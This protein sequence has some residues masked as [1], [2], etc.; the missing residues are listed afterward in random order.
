MPAPTVKTRPAMR[1][2]HPSPPADRSAAGG[3]QV[4][5]T[6]PGASTSP[7]LPHERDE[8]V[9]STGG[10]P[11]ERVAQAAADL[12]RGVRDTSRG[13]EADAA[14]AKLKPKGRKA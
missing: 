8:S 11:S 7:A 4:D 3:V 9:G 1:P 2:K 14:Y 10:V 5:L 6:A 13:T 12:A